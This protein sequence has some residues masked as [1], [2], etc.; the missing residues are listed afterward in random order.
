PEGQA[1]PR[2]GRPR[3]GRRRQG[4]PRRHP[5]GRSRPSRGQ[6]AA[7]GAVQ[8]RMRDEPE[9]KILGRILP[10]STASVGSRLRLGPWSAGLLLTLDEFDAAEF[11][12]GW[13]Y[14]LIHEV[15]VVSP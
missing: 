3:Q 1:R 9:L 10:M 4:H 11:E 13:R 14:E 8:G 5:E 2:P 12:E 15:L 7:G 6:G